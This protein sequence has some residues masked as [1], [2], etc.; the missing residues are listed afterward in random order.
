[1]K[2]KKVKVLPL[3]LTLILFLVLTGCS[4]SDA[5]T[6]KEPVVYSFNGENEQFTITNG[7]IILNATEEV[8]YG[9]NLDLK[10]DELFSDVTSFSTTFYT[11]ADGEK[12][13]ILSNAVTDMTENSVNV[14]GD[15]GKIS[16]AEALLST[17]ID[18]VR[19]LQNNLYFEITTTNLNGEEKTYQLQL[20]LMEITGKE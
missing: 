12:K 19:E 1:M 5:T 8:F 2:T 3:F 20:S 6:I 10:Q 13:T 7:V 4:T 9:G 14:T 11:M 15:L 18:D 16:G 17:K